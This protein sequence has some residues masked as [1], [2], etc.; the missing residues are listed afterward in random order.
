VHAV[1]ADPGLFGPESVT[2]RIHGDPVSFVG[3]LRALLLQALHPLAMAGVEQHSNYRQDPWGR[4]SRTARYVSTATFGTTEEAEAAAARVRAV[5]RHIRGVDAVTGLDY[6]ADDP[7]LL[8]WV[9][10][11]TVDSV[12]DAYARAGTRLSAADADAYVA[13]QVRMATLMRLAPG[14]VPDTVAGLA[15][16]FDAVR[17]ELR[18]TPA[19]R[20]VALFGVAPPMPTWVR[21]ATPARLAWAGVSTLAFALLP[22][23]ARR[24]YGV[25]VLPGADLATDLTL[26]TLR[27]AALAVPES[28]RTS[29]EHK[30]AW[31]RLA[32]SA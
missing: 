23:W 9:H 13:E 24:M 8:A 5:H 4:L 10:N 29:P 32:E 15:D 31:A 1:A 20:R 6:R 30:A 14:A 17:G 25:P 28:L 18:I 12:L 16:Y 21:V 7:R 2:W 3:G 26:R 27:T 22:A 19:A 11:A